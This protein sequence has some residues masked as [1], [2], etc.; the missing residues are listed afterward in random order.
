M[1]L[2][3][4]SSTSPSTLLISSR[5]GSSTRELKTRGRLPESRCAALIWATTSRAFSVESMKGSVTR[6]KSMPSNWEMREEPR[7]STVRPVRSETKK[8]RRRWDMEGSG[9]V[10]FPRRA[11]EGR[12]SVADTASLMQRSI[13]RK[14]PI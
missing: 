14:P 10:D 13:V 3:K 1:N 9:I 4:T 12:G 5:T 6:T 11:R 7:A 2:P 8:T